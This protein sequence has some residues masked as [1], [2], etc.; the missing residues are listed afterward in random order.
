VPNDQDHKVLV[1]LDR[2]VADSLL[3]GTGLDLGYHHAKVKM[4]EALRLALGSNEAR[5]EGQVRVVADGGRGG[6]VVLAAHVVD[7]R[8]AA[9]KVR[10]HW[11]K[12]GLY[13]RVRIQARNV[14]EW[15]DLDKGEVAG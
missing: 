5:L 14:T 7:G 3:N 1:E 15:R 11:A 10:G 12:G 4:R 8:E 2:D 13:E 9:A 6:V